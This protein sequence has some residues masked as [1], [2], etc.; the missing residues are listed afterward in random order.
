M[1]VQL[2]VS[3]K[4]GVEVFS[5]SAEHTS[6]V[7][8][9]NQMLSGFMNAMQ[10]FSEKMGNPVQQ[11]QFSNL[12]L[13]IRTYGDFII[14][15]LMKE[16]MSEED[17]EHYFARLSKEIVPLLTDQMVMN[18]QLKQMLKEKLVP[19]I[20]PLIQDPLAGIKKEDFSRD[21]FLSKIALAGLAKA[22]KTSIKRMFF[23]NWS[24]EMIRDI[25]PTIGIETTRKF[26]E[27]L[28]HRF[29]IM[30][31]GGQIT[32]REQHLRQEGA[33]RDLSALVYVVDLQDVDSFDAAAEY[34]SNIWEVIMRISKNRPKL[35]IFL[36]K[37]DIIRRDSLE[38]NIQQCLVSFKA[39]INTVSF[40][41]TTIEDSS[42]NEALVKTLYFSLPKIMIKRLFEQEFLDYFEGKILPI[43]FNL[44]QEENFSRIIIERSHE[45]RQGAVVMGMNF[46]LSLQESW[47]KYLMGEWVPKRRLLTSKTIE[48]KE[49][50]Q[51][52]Y[53][54]VPDWSDQ[55][56]PSILT[57]VL[58]DGM[59][60]GVLKTFHL[61]PPEKTGE[62]GIFTTWKITL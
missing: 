25:K 46:G 24:R 50:G 21:G 9:N 15:L 12:M 28:E 41:L 34:L 19:I 2:S 49:E 29:V 31:Y 17:I 4:S 7:I 27:F 23:E 54:T 39:F 11:I 48:I 13:Y 45:L 56:I 20:A 42:S 14:R 58:F 10:V 47:M 1:L 16:K 55:D 3:T 60:E 57:K 6:G 26:H 5:Y 53:I 8:A 18:L 30:D 32:Y 38:N 33:W 43:F 51:H 61:N 37:C 59:L 36:H 40:H 44:T 62:R 22:G 35:S 52:I